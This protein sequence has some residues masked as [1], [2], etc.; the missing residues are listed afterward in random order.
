M[1]VSHAAQRP[2]PRRSL[3]VRQTFGLVGNVATFGEPKTIQSR[4]NILLIDGARAALRDQRRRQ[5][6][7]RLLVGRAWEDTGLV[8][9]GPL[10][11][12]LDPRIPSKRLHTHLAPVGLGTLRVH[13]LR[14][15]FCSLLLRQGVS[16]VAAAKLLGHSSPAVTMAVYAHLAEDSLAEAAG[17]LNDLAVGS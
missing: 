10:G 14:H 8:F 16:I 11:G 9:T 2:R 4:R 1:P 13:D 7:D 6:E 17:R 3:K 15:A 5:A 12:P